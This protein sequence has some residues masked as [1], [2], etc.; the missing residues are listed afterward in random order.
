MKGKDRKAAREALRLVYYNEQ[1]GRCAICEK[2]LSKIQVD[3]HEQHLD[4]CHQTGQYR[5]LLC[6]A[7]N[8]LLGLAG[9][10]PEVLEAAA[11]Y[12]RRFNEH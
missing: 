12:L 9:D 11:E 5:G 1:G 6:R 10:R 2:S 8:H 3:S 4:H 7:C